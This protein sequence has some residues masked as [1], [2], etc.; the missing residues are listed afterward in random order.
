MP[1]NFDP[2]SLDGI[3]LAARQAEYPNTEAEHKAV[4]EIDQKVEEMVRGHEESLLSAANAVLSEGDNALQAADE[5]RG[6]LRNLYTD[7]ER[8]GLH[9]GPDLAKHYQSISG[10]L[11]NRIE[12]L[13]RVQRNAE[14][15]A[16]KIVDPY[17]SLDYIRRKYPQVVAGRRF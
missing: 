6:E 12:R 2:R 8:A 14:F 17:G 1:T 11:R 7:L 15:Q 5:L 13:R 9:A 10:R 16:N 3:R 4:T